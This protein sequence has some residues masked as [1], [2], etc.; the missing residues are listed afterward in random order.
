MLLAPLESKQT[1]QINS[2]R[3]RHSKI[4]C[5]CS[6][7]VSLR[8]D[9][10]PAPP[11]NGEPCN[12]GPCSISLPGTGPVMS[13]SQDL[14]RGGHAGA[15]SSKFC[16]GCDHRERETNSLVARGRAWLTAGGVRS[17]WSLLAASP[18]QGGLLAFVCSRWDV[19]GFR[20]RR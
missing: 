12:P 5:D 19:R 11:A 1:F 8:C 17:L 14:L 10:V 2:G 3:R 13:T 4:F 16:Q 15:G 6:L 20:H 9:G 7:N 18:P